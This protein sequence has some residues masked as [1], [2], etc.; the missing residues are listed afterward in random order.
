MTDLPSGDDPTTPKDTEAAA[1]AAQEAE[2]RAAAARARAQ[3]LRRLAEAGVLAPTQ[4]ETATET[5]TATAAAPRRRIHWVGVC[6]AAMAAAIC[7]SAGLSGAMLWQRHAAQQ[8]QQR[9]AEYSAVAKQS[10]IN[11][12][13]LDYNDAKGSVQRVIDGST[14]KFK[15]DFSAQSDALIKEMQKS[16]VVTTVTVQSVV[17]EQHSADSAVVLVAAQS[18][19]TNVKD[20]RKEPQKFRVVITLA[21]DNGQIKASQ[22][23]FV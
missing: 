5:L 10:A 22:V 8:Q 4:S 12:M 3:E 15:D 11:L 2:S 17:V 23:E 14:G 16:K 6:A 9:I 19:A 18:Q 21:T 7:A 1:A 20:E 13:S